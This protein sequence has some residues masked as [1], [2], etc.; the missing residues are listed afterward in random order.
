M[1]VGSNKRNATGQKAQVGYTFFECDGGVAVAFG[2]VFQY[3][4]GQI[5][6]HRRAVRWVRHPFPLCSHLR[7]GALLRSVVSLLTAA[8]RRLAAARRCASRAVA[9]QR[10]K[11]FA[12]ALR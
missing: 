12:L 4:V 11:F 6:E 1:Q 3:V 2:M 5:Y 7:L 8:A 10:K 9:S